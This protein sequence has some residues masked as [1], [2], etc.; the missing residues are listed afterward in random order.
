MSYIKFK[1]PV[2]LGKGYQFAKGVGARNIIIHNSGK[3]AK[4]KYDN[5]ALTIGYEIQPLKI[6]KEKSYYK[7]T[8]LDNYVNNKFYSQF[9]E[10]LYNIIL[11]LKTLIQIFEN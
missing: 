7:T 2:K 5:D 3:M 4:R 11:M 8:K 6:R 9:K 10:K 1:F